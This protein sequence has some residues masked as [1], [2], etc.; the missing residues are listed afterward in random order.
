MFLTPNGRFETQKKVCLS[1]SNHH[2]EHWQP[3]W[4]VRTALVALIAFLPTPAEGALGSLEYTKE[5]RER[6]AQ[7]SRSDFPSYGNEERQEV[8]RRVHELMLNVEGDARGR[9]LDTDGPEGLEQQRHQEDEETTST[10]V[11]VASR[12]EEEDGK[13]LHEVGA[14]R[15]VDQLQLELEAETN[16]SQEHQVR[17]AR[18]V[19]GDGAMPAS[20]PTSSQDEPPPSTTAFLPE[21]EEDEEDQ[22][23]TWLD[24]NEQEE[25]EPLPDAPTAPV[26]QTESLLLSHARELD[27]RSLRMITVAVATALLAII[28]KKLMKAVHEVSMQL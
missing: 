13:V 4:G 23:T 2:P 28:A 8:T 18:D 26:R 6:L 14:S 5:E 11:E 21:K 1:I 3:T 15:H 7:Q 19:A 12:E 10:E 16:E 24:A 17:E 9:A 25:I 22:C 20:A 27:D